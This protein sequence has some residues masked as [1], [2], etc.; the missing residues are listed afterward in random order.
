MA[1]LASPYRALYALLYG[2]WQ[3]RRARREDS[4]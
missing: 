1:T 3:R 4:A 2:R